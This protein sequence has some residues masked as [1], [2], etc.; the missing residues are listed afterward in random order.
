[1]GDGSEEQ[2]P[3]SAHRRLLSSVAVSP[4]PS[5]TSGVL[6]T[7]GTGKLAARSSAGWSAGG[8]ERWVGPCHTP[9]TFHSV[10]TL[11][12]ETCPSNQLLR[13]LG[14]MGCFSQSASLY[15][16]VPS[17]PPL[18]SLYICVLFLKES[19]LHGITPQIG[20]FQQCQPT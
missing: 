4:S 9:P 11:Q 5:E 6:G 3:G 13:L 8:K 17:P 15:L 14:D 10:S 18:I 16:S 1:M 2:L 19:G 7:G 20:C 12:E